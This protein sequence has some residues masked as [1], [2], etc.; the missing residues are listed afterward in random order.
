MKRFSVILVILLLSVGTHLFADTSVLLDFST[1]VADT[2]G[3]NEATMVDFSAQAGTG[4]TDEER[5]AMKTSLAIE[6]W[7]VELASSSS[8]IETGCRAS[9]CAP[10]PFTARAIRNASS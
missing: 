4:F 9:F 6:N 2:D 10:R 5:Q 8:T 7:E 3:E 1:L